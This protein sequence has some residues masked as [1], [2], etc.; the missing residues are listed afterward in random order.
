MLNFTDSALSGSP[1]WNLTPL[2]I[3]NSH[4]CS[5]TLVQDSAT[6]PTSFMVSGF[7]AIR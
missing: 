3:R 5:S 2:R 6:P 4:V 1:L 7:R